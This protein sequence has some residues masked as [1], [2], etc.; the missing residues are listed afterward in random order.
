MSL[1]GKSLFAVMMR[2]AIPTSDTGAKLFTTSN[3]NFPA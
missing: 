1:A 3:G 2:G